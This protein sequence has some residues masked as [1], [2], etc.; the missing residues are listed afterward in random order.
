MKRSK[1]Y[2]ISVLAFQE[3]KWWVAQCLEY[4]IATQ[5]KS[6]PDLYY[7]LERTLVGHLVVSSEL[8]M[9]P[10]AALKPAPPRYWE[11]FEKSKMHVK[12]ERRHFKL[13][14]LSDLIPTPEL[15]VAE[16]L[17]PVPA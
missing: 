5:A 17:V 10:F 7:E 3:G 4:D 12:R 16:Q 9:E 1:E 13:P 11:A 6:L 14:K 15:R 2:K 8:A